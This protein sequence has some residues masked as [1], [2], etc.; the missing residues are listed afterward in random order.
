MKKAIIGKK[1]GMTQVFDETGKIV[2]VTVVEAG[3]CVVVQK[4][5]VETDGYEAVQLG[6]GDVREKLLN[7]PKKGHFAKAGVSLRRH[8]KEFRFE[9]VSE[10]E[11]GQE[12][13]A[14]VFAVGDKVD[15]SGVSKGKGFA[16]VIKRWGQ[17]RG[18]MSHGSKFKR[19]PG[20]M[21]ASSDP[22]RTFKSKKLPGHMGAVNRTVLN[23]EVVKVMP[24]KNLILIK[25]GVP[26]ANKGIVVIRDSVKC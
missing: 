1:I 26:G 5:T 3:P 22:S 2:P 20:S 15:V 14:D 23:V 6:F 16:G 4:K 11:V 19:A 25:G 9:N 17:Q 18:P 13:K 24:E 8:L 21:G 7:K 12:I 10:Y